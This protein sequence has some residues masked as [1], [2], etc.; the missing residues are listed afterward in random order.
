MHVIRLLTTGP[1]TSLKGTLAV[2]CLAGL[3]NAALI[4]LI[5][6]VGEKA[7]LAEPVSGT[8]LLLYVGA[9]AFF[10]IASRA[11]LHEANRMLQ[12][13]L[14]MLR[15]RIVDKIR[16]APLRAL[17]QIGQG[18][19]YA[20]VA[21]E[22]N[23]LSQN[24]P[25]FVSAVQSGFLLVFCLLYIAVLS[26]PSFLVVGAFTA[27]GLAI[28][29]RRRV[30]LNRAL[31]G[32]YGHETA[33]LDGM[34]S[35]T[36]GF[37]EIRL[38][39]DKNDAL[40]HQFTRTVS[41]LETA[42]TGIGSRWVALMQFSNA[43]LYALVGVV[44][45]VLPMFFHG[46]NDVIYKVAAAA[47]FCVGPVTAI[48]SAS[49]LYAKADTG[50]GHV[51]RMEER[52]DEAVARTPPTPDGSRFQGFR[53][54]DFQDITFS[55]RDADGQV[56]FTSGPWSFALN[57]GEIVFLVGGNG[58]GKST[59]MKLM[60]G[61]YPPDGGGILVDGAPVTPEIRQE[62]R[63][64]FSGI[65]PDFHLFDRLYG[66]GDVDPARVRALIHRME[67][68]EKTDFKDGRFTATGLSTGQ[69]KRLAMIA[70]LLEDREI[71]L[72]DEW[73]ADQDSRFRDVF[74]TEILPDLKRRGKTVLAVTHDDRYWSCCDRRLTL[75]LGMIQA[76]AAEPG[77]PSAG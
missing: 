50:L 30:V 45:F 37:Q 13:R 32:V 40:F 58:S 29:W 52:L 15:L 65:F 2:T 57:R 28:F 60:S 6:E 46:Y 26:P 53:R 18:E 73:A 25:L 14:G 23:H 19:L 27:L 77:A 70:A 21:Q 43:F 7:A 22:T 74:Y 35:F 62:Y 3:G 16:H 5:N 31:G 63:E 41:E 69:R 17:E 47:I 48:T 12:H 39:A 36:E 34:T 20:V 64:L 55:Y 42:V 4:G 44:I 68:D 51:Y 9:F 24:L 54:I 76:E 72:F 1:R 61:L 59:A 71:Y 33:M 38:N 75:D 8:L 49:H 10:Y 56:V 67:L 66:L 11:S